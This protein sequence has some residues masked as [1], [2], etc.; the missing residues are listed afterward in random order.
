MDL[1]CV[2]RSSV[3][4]LTW[5]QVSRSYRCTFVSTGTAKNWAYTQIMFLLFCCHTSSANQINTNSDFRSRVTDLCLPRLPGQST[6]RLCITDVIG[7]LQQRPTDHLRLN[8]HEADQHLTDWPDGVYVKRKNRNHVYNIFKVL[9]H[10]RTC[11]S[12]FHTTT[13]PSQLAD[14]WKRE[15]IKFLM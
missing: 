12:I 10:W 1:T 2:S 15:Q 4:V 8:G 14:A 7:L 13:E 3:R 6:Q 11:S 5:F 9:K